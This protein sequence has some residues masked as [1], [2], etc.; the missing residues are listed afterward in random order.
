MDLPPCFP[1]APGQCVFPGS[2][3]CF[4]SKVTLTEAQLAEMALDYSMALTD[5]IGLQ[6]EYVCSDAESPSAL[7]TFKK[8]TPLER[9]ERY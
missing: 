7:T 1:E 2:C 5:I 6:N 4:D 3:P 8:E 9:G